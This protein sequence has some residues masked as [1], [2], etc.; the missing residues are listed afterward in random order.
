MVIDV[1]GIPFPPAMIFVISPFSKDKSTI[2]RLW[3]GGCN[4]CATYKKRNQ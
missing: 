2:I 1:M 3:E 4:E